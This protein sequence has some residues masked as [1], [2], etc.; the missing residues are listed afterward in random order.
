M[1]RKCK[2]RIIVPMIIIIIGI[3]ATLVVIIYL[4]N[5]MNRLIIGTWTTPG[6]TLYTFNKDG[7]GLMKVPL[8][9]YS[10]TY[11]IE[12]GK[13]LIDF[14]DKNVFDPTYEYSMNKNVLTLKG[15]KGTFTFR[16]VVT[17]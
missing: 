17:K 2:K 1:R 10:F 14:K 6:G 16:K 9:E 3:I 5:D 7:A 15:E 11:K 13:L 8:N 4:K 12:D